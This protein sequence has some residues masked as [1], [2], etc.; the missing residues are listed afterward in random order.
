MFK[1]KEDVLLT[2]SPK[3]RYVYNPQGKVK[4][5][6]IDYGSKKS[7]LEELGKRNCKVT[8]YPANTE[9]KEI[10][11]NDFDAV[12]LSSG[13]GN[14]N[15]YTFQIA[16]IRQLMGKIP[17][18]GISLGCQLL[19]LASGASVSKLLHGHRGGSYPVIN[20]ENNKV[21][22][23]AQNHG[24]VIDSENMTKFMRPT[25]KNLNENSIEGFEINSLSV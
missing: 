24:Y 20:L 13:P 2:V 11:E 14:P 9:A 23:T 12:F 17:I 1:I 18:F 21:I 7:V 25:H 19:A 5:A 8:V 10:L 15:N 4:I 16:Q 3:S 6:Y 22:M